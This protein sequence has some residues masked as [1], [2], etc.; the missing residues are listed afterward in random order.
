VRA[1]AGRRAPDGPAV[2]EGPAVPDVS[3]VIVSYN[4]CALLDGCLRSVQA[5]T[6]VT[7]ETWVVDNAS[8]DGSADHVA[9][10][11]PDVRLIRNGANRGFAAANNLAI[12]AAGGRYL[13]LLNPD[14]VVRQNTVAR[15]TEFLDGHPAIGITGPRVLNRD[16]S[17]QS[18]G[19]RYPT[20]AR[21]IAMS[22]D[23]RRAAGGRRPEPA[24]A[25]EVSRDVDWIDGCCLM[26][27]RA[28]VDRIGPLDERFFLYA[29]ELDWC[30]TAGAAGVRIATCPSAAMTHFGGQSTAQVK[31]QSL[32]MFI[33]TRLRYYHKHDGLP[34]ATLVAAMYALGC[35]R[36]WRGERDKSRAKLLGI[37]RWWQG[38][39]ATVPPPGTIQIGGSAAGV[40]RA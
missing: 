1:A 27:R 30:R 32:A 8:P 38:R 10:T 33:E 24:D 3:V 18:C 22:R 4:T 21:E 17:I 20:L 7:L 39:G 19:Y 15:L 35:A 25:L 29:E 31:G 28:V 34:T 23:G 36:H 5:S 6:G 37:Q 9:A 40:R 26:I 12:A 14:T 13:L 11:F 16:G 2:P